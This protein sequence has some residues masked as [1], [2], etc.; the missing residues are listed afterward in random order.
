MHAMTGS[1]GSPTDQPTDPVA[2]QSGTREAKSQCTPYVLLSSYAM[3][4]DS[5][6]GSA[7]IV[8]MQAMAALHASMHPC[9]CDVWW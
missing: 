2:D 9:V 7:G 3:T 1:A 4:E 5:C 6:M 8:L